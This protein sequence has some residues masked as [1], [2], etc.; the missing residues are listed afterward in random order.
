[1]RRR[2]VCMVVGIPYTNCYTAEV[3]KAHLESAGFEDVVV[4]DHTEN[5][6]GGFAVWAGKHPHWAVRI[7]GAAIAMAR[8]AAAL[9]FVIVGAK[10]RSRG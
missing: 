5:V 4:V 10:R 1:M 9:R 2:V 3:Y 8:D 6:L 7:A